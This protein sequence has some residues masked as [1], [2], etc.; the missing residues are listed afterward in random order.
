VLFIKLNTLI[1]KCSAQGQRVYYS[2]RGS[3]NR[4]R[5]KTIHYLLFLFLL[6][7]LLFLFIV[8]TQHNTIQF[9]INYV[10]S[11]QLQG[12]LQAKHSEVTGN[13]I[14]DRHKMKTMTNYREALEEENTLIQK[15]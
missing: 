10:P 11:Q 3:S 6:L 15:K 4:F 13:Y 2:L 9:F 7:L 14:M 1:G 12:Q 8:L 5:T